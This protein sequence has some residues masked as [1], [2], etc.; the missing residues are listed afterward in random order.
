MKKL[1][2]LFAVA[3]CSA[4]SPSVTP[5][6]PDAGVGDDVDAGEDVSCTNDSCVIDLHDRVAQDCDPDALAELTAAL[7]ARRGRWPFWASGRALFVSDGPAQIAGEFNG[8]AADADATT[9]LCGTGFSTAI[10]GVGSGRWPYKLVVGDTWKLDP[11]NWGFVFDDFA[12]NADGKNSVIDTPDSGL[13]HLVQ[14]PEPVCSEELGNCRMLTAY[15]PPG[16]DDPANAAHHYPVVFM[17]DGQNI[18]DDH[19]CCFGHTGWEVNV[20]MDEGIA[21][22]ELEA[23]VIVGADNT[24]ARM[25][26]YGWSTS[27]GGAIEPFM[28]FQVGTV[29]PT[30]ADYWRLDA[31]RA[32]IAGSSLGGLV[33]MRLALAYPQ[34]YAGAAAVSGAFW[35]GQDTSTALADFLADTGKVSVPVYIDHG[36]TAEDGGDGYQDAIA[37]RDQMMALGWTRGDSPSCGSGPDALCYY[38]EPGATHDELAWKARTWRFL[39]FFIGQ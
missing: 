13:G 9:P 31:A 6:D 18:F 30:A 28:A 29:Q 17:H 38:W 25:D 27:A 32:Y 23:A 20:A 19:D 2:L 3:A 34:T 16:Y 33:S 4:P 22:G 11:G 10:V 21:A 8:W 12:G 37:I 26:E 36:G 7:E 15:L 14:P 24:A 5:P 39:R 1:A 35:P